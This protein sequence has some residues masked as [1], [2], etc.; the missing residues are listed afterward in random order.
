MLPARGV[1]QLLYPL[2][3]Y[4]VPGDFDGK[5]K[6]L[7]KPGW[8]GV[9][10]EFMESFREGR[11]IGAQ[12]AIYHKG[13]LVVSICAGSALVNSRDFNTG[14]GSFDPTFIDMTVDM[15]HPL[16]SS[17]KV[18][19]ST[20]IAMLA[21][22]GNLDV[23][24]K[25][26]E[27]WPEFSNGGKETLEVRDIMRH[28]GA[29]ANPDEKF[30]LDELENL[31]KLGVKLARQT[32]NWDVEKIT[33]QMYHPVTRG[34]Y[35]GEIARRADPKGRSMGQYFREEVA[36]KYGGIKFFMGINK[37]EWK[38]NVVSEQ[39]IPPYLLLLKYIPQYI[40][41]PLVSKTTW[42]KLLGD[43]HDVL[44]DYE[45]AI[46]W[47]FVKKLFNRAYLLIAS[48]GSVTGVVEGL[49]KI[50]DI[51]DVRVLK[52]ESMA[53]ANGL[54]NAEG[55]AKLG[56]LIMS[57]ELFDTKGP[58]MEVGEVMF[59]EGIGF[60]LAYTA[61]GYGHERFANSGLPGWK[62]WAGI[63]GSVLQY[64]EELDISFAYNTVL[65]YMR[66]G[67]PRGQRLMKVAV[68]AAKKRIVKE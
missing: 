27:I 64:N 17:T 2:L 24:G 19:E 1:V 49:N 52:L 41:G 40:M 16:F 61:C 31:D 53:S 13:E 63:A 12:V 9:R 14:E 23:N 45:R 7:V 62:G 4:P 8:E 10:D 3:F 39:L 21:D 20:V 44:D 37:E 25:V 46:V 47:G 68:E 54:A 18:A 42:A 65:P 60:D 51:N 50:E 67:K 48:A 15:V 29:L 66:V 43:D 55:M 26:S 11:E 58:S 6:G 28:Q 32:T 33:H 30:S 56:Q 22:S 34:M 36:N 57:G 35:A 38:A 5:I 59:D